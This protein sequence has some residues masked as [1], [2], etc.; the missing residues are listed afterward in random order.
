MSVSVWTPD[1]AQPLTFV[2]DHSESRRVLTTWKV[3]EGLL[4]VYEFEWRAV[5]QAHNDFE[6]VGERCVATFNVAAWSRVEGAEHV[7]WGH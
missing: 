7:P 5:G 2:D 4:R 1:A 6:P 3:D